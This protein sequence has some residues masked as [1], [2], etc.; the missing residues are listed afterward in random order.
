MRATLTIPPEKA[1]QLLDNSI[2]LGNHIGQRL[3]EKHVPVT[4][5]IVPTIDATRATGSLTITTNADR[6]ITVLA[7]WQDT[8]D[9]L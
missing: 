7:D 2:H 5:G 9:D 4:R 8:D 3:R 6:S 1:A